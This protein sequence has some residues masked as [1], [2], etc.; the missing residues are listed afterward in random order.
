MP[1]CQGQVRALDQ[2]HIGWTM[3]FQVLLWSSYLSC[4]D[5]G[6]R[7]CHIDWV[8][9][10]CLLVKG[11]ITDARFIVSVMVG[12]ICPK[13]QHGKYKDSEFS[14]YNNTQANVI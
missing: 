11:K 6:S 4:L 8:I 14:L 7:S 9:R 1:L 5:Q 3:R 12:K 2:G 13:P 10:L